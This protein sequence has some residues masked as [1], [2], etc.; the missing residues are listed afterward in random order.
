MHENTDLMI[1]S[2][3]QTPDNIP[4]HINL[5]VIMDEEESKVEQMFVFD[6]DE[7]AN[8]DDTLSIDLIVCPS[9]NRQCINI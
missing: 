2:E 7:D 9:C 5:S 3:E 4:T 1:M 6:S 8:L